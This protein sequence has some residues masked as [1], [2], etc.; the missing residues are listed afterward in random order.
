VER[1]AQF[2]KVF[3]ESLWIDKLVKASGNVA[4]LAW[5]MVPILAYVGIVLSPESLVHFPHWP[6][7]LA[8]GVYLSWKAAIAWDRTRGPLIWTDKV[9]FD[10]YCRLW[11]MAVENR[12]TGEVFA[13]VFLVQLED[14]NGERIERID[15]PI[16]AHWRGWS[17]EAAMSLA[18]ERQGIAALL[19]E[20]QDAQMDVLGL[21]MWPAAGLVPLLTPPLFG[22]RT[23]KLFLIVRVEFCDEKGV[24]LKTMKRRLAIVPSKGT[25]QV[26]EVPLR[27]RRKSPP[28]P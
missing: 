14:E 11:E 4:R 3:L 16:Q 2:L 17:E 5:L 23:R 7:L 18:A 6:P 19:R 12:G 15:K 8:L 22:Y 9:R 26:V 21:A 24:C 1:L 27:F 20:Y 13:R 25:F 10:K 28:V